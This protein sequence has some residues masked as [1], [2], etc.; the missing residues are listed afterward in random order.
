MTKQV[1]N[2]KQLKSKDLEVA[3][4]EFPIEQIQIPVEGTAPL[5]VHAFSQKARQMI[6]DK[7]MKKAKE[8]KDAKNPQE[9]YEGSIYWIDKKNNRTGFPAAGFK[10]GMIRAGK[11]LGY[12]MKDLQGQFRIIGDHVNL[13]EIHGEHEMN[14]SMVRIGQGVADVRFRAIYMKWSA[15]ITVQY[16]PKF[17][18]AD[19]IVSLLNTAGFVAG[20]GENRPE[21]SKGGDFGTYKVS[22]S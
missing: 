19:Q 6:L 5:L 17:I 4:K 2:T 14:E 9:Q 13:V 1:E 11:Q 20:I 18:S 22:A 12:V 15:T 21:K 10:I 3:L 7:Q 16:S 8:G